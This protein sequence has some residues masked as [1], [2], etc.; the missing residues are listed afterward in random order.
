M[1]EVMRWLD[2]AGAVLEARL[3]VL[4][5]V[6]IIRVVDDCVP[7]KIIVLCFNRF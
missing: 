5:Y 4:T 3:A 2:R 7:S 6:S 1:D